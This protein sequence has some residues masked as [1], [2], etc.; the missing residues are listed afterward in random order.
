MAEGKFVAS[1]EYE[2]Y[3]NVQVRIRARGAEAVEN[4]ERRPSDVIID[5]HILIHPSQNVTFDIDRLNA[6]IDGSAVTSDQ[7]AEAKSLLS[8][9]VEFKDRRAISLGSVMDCSVRAREGSECF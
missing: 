8:T 3:A 6:A 7:K 9:T 2:E 1:D 4:P 5:Q